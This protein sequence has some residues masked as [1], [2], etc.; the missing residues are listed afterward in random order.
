[1]AQLGQ[2]P[3]L[4][5]A[6]QRGA[7]AVGG[8]IGIGG[9]RG[10]H[11]GPIGHGGADI[12]QR[13]GQRLFQ[14]TALAG[15]GARGFQIDHRFALFARRIASGDRAQAPF[16]IAADGQHGVD[17]PVNRQP[18]GGNG[19]SNRIDQKRHVIVDHRDSHEPLARCAGD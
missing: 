6:Q 1:M 15:I 18:V 4:E 14:R 11:R 13:R 12:G 9:H 5:P 19:G 17:Q 2:H 7:F 10:L 16:A 3:V 8:G